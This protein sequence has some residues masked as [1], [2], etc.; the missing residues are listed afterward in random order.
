MP[1]AHAEPTITTK[2]NDQHLLI[3]VHWSADTQN[4]AASNADGSKQLD[5]SILYID[6]DMDAKMTK[7]LDMR[8]QLNPWPANPGMWLGKYS[9]KKGKEIWYKLGQV[10]STSRIHH[11]KTGRKDIFTIPAEILPKQ[12]Q[13]QISYHGFSPADKKE[14]RTKYEK[15]RLQNN[16]KIDLSAIPDDRITRHPPAKTL[17]KVGDTA[18]PIHAKKWI[19]DEPNGAKFVAFWATWCGPCVE[20][21]PKLNQLYQDGIPV[22]GV[23]NQIPPYVKKFQGKTAMNYPTA[24]GSKSELTYG[25]EALPIY[26]IIDKSNKI[27]W[28]DTKFDTAEVKKAFIGLK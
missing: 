1:F 25:V 15:I 17:L 22:V 20:S 18:P 11:D 10:D 2:S 5:H 27:I 7:D 3:E 4:T 21:I 26:F 9:E 14:V 12:E 28:T 16:D 19:G 6:V 8:I 23:T 24:T 13:L